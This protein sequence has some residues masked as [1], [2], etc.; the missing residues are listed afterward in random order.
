VQVAGG[1]PQLPAALVAL[2]HDPA[3]HVRSAE[4]LLRAFD[5]ALRDARAHPGTRPSAFAVGH[6]RLGEGIETPALAELFEIADATA[7]PATEAKVH[8]HHHG[9]GTELADQHALDE[10]LRR[11]ARELDREGA[12]DDVD[13]RA[14]ALAELDLAIQRREQRRRQTP[15]RDRGVRLEGEHPRRE[16]TLARGARD[17][18]EH[19]LMA[20]M[21]AVE[22]A[23]DDESVAWCR[24]GQGAGRHSAGAAAPAQ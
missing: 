23:D 8:A 17:V 11:L 15:Q 1:K 20:A 18:L 7:S 2:R 19:G 6:Q 10:L 3:H 16:R 14:M 24:H 21:H 12:H 5:I 9:G 22:V 4:D 13:A